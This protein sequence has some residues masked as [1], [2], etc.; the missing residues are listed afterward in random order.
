VSVALPDVNVLVALTWPSHVHHRAASDWFAGLGS[1]PWAT[2]PFT[3]SGFIR[4][5]SN[6]RIVDPA[7]SPQAALQVLRRLASMGQHHFWPDD[8]DFTGDAI[9]VTL[10][11]GHRQVTDAYLL[12]LAIH[13]GGRLVTLDREITD[14][15][16]EASPHRA[17]VEVLGGMPPASR[18]QTR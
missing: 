5:S 7:V 14:L 9:P 8:L 13:R 17:N 18:S 11:M 10:L 12:G 2:C 16:A 3:Q 6:P 4:V 1:D 15:L